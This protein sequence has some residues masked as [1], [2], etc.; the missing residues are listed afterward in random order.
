MKLNLILSGTMPGIG[1]I[2]RYLMERIMK[3]V[4]AKGQAVEKVL[5][6]TKTLKDKK[7]TKEDKNYC[8]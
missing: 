7:S 2:A 8:S 1:I 5:Y 6:F 4:K 3:R